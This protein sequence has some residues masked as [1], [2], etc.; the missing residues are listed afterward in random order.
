MCEQ[1]PPG[2]AEQI[3][4]IVRLTARQLQ[5]RYPGEQPTLRGVHPKDH[6]CVKAAFQV[7]PDLRDDLRV[8]VFAEAGRTYSAWV[9]FSNAFSIIRPDSSLADDG[10]GRKAHDSRG[11]AVKLLGVSGQPLIDPPHGALTQDFLMV[12]H[13]VFAF[14]NAEDYE[15]LSRVITEDNE[16]IR[17]F[18]AIQAAKGGEVA[19]RANR[20][21]QIIGRLRADSVANGAF[22]TPRASP[23][24][25]RYFSAAPFLFGKGRVMK[26]SATPV[27]PPSNREPNIADPNY[28]RT[29]LIERLSNPQAPPVTFHFQV[30]VRKT[31]EI[32]DVATEI[33]NASTEWPEA[34]FP[35][36]TVAT[37]TIPPQFFDSGERR[38]VCEDLFFTPWHGVEDHRPLGGINRLRR[39][40]YEMSVAIR[41]LTKEPGEAW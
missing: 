11:M 22:Q 10:S 9:R 41:Q 15:V 30:Q 35:F 38:T 23:L 13:A 20:T 26:F 5:N 4:S 12:N 40:V 32:G 21:R 6:G 34:D 39:A 31:G 29:A 18:F 17:R 8:G 37:I 3:E 28:L 7:L 1:I 19:A 16:D 2:E 24:E 36:E 27:G 33:E 14:A 25:F